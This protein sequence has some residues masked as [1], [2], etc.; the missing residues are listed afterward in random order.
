MWMLSFVKIADHPYD[1]S[2]LNQQYQHASLRGNDSLS[3]YFQLRKK[4][5]AKP[6]SVFNI[7]EHMQGIIIVLCL[8]KQLC[9][10]AKW[11]RLLQCVL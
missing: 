9:S 7:F 6:P 2:L 5:D 11:S 10:Y 1:F 8:N 3:T 4:Q